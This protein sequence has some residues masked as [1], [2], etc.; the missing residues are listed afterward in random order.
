MWILCYRT[1]GEVV[2]VLVLEVILLSLSPFLFPFSIRSV[3]IWS[4]PF[5]SKPIRFVP[6]QSELISF[7]PN[8]HFQTVSLRSYLCSSDLIQPVSFQY[9]LLR[10]YPFYFWTIRTN[11]FRSNLC[12][13]AFRYNLIQSN[14]FV[15]DTLSS[16]P[17]QYCRDQ[18]STAINWNFI[19]LTAQKRYHVMTKSLFI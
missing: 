18:W 10:T 16:Y 8:E 7:V 1:Q 9:V 19:V 4:V 15:S 12:S 3:P 17:V 2:S 14:L 13:V 6:R 11:L 5:S